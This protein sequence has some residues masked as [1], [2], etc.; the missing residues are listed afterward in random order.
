MP[1][2]LRTVL[3]AL[4]ALCCTTT[5]CS[6]STAVLAATP[7][8]TAEAPPARPAVEATAVD[9]VDAEREALARIAHELLA[10]Q[11]Q[12]RDAARGAPTMARVQ[13]RY[14]WLDSDLELIARGIRDHLDAPRQPRAIVPLKGDYRH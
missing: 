1:M 3:I 9:K 5:A 10:L 8:E 14:D 4:A 11:E 7:T 2:R 13:F 6:T 12:V